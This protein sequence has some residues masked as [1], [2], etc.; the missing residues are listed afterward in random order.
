MLKK[1]Y[2]G[3][4]GDGKIVW[5]ERTVSLGGGGGSDTYRYWMEEKNGKFVNGGWDPTSPNPDF[6]WRPQTD[7]MFTGKNE[8]NPFVDP[9]MVK[10]IYEASIR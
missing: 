1:G 8:R 2:G 9:K 5:V 6:L 4:A 10:E 3:P 7:A